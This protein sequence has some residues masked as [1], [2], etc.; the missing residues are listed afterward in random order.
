MKKVGIFICNY[1]GKQYV[2][3]CIRSLMSQT[4]Q[5][6]DIYVVDNASTDGSAEGIAENFGNTVHVLQNSDNLGGAGG[7]DR[8]LKYGLNSGYQYIALLDNDI[9]L[10]SEAIGKLYEYLEEHEDT[11]IVGAKI[12]VMDEPDLIQDF[13]NYIDFENYR[14]RLCYCNIK[15]SELIPEVHECDYVPSC[16]ILIRSEMLEIS[17]TM[18]A[19][20]FIYYDDIE[21][22]YKMRKNNFKVA[23]YGGAKVWHKGG[24]RK[25]AVNT[26]SKYYFLR[27]RL[28]FFAKYISDEKIE[29]FADAVM[30]DVFMQLYGFY[31]KGMKEL[32]D[33][34]MY[35]FDDFLHG[36]RGKAEEQK[37][38]NI[39]K[40][41]I[42]FFN[43]IKGKK[44]VFIRFIDNYSE[45]DELDI[46]HIFLFIL[47][48]IIQN[49]ENIETNVCLDCCGVNA[50]EFR[51]K[52]EKAM[53][54]NKDKFPEIL[55]V[56][57][58]EKEQS[59]IILQMCKHVNLVTEK[60]FPEIYV[61]QYCNCITDEKDY[62]YF[63]SHENTYG[64]FQAMYR[65]LLLEGIRKI[66]EGQ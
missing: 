29:I 35:A 41:D 34:T 15:D 56:N 64:L 59:D 17:G 9:T 65:P 14:E 20:N 60:I 57:E 24:F 54:V 36:V 39:I 4:M 6:F 58:R 1:N 53:G 21:L 38:F 44:R 66:R 55:V 40:R 30:K 50:D 2:I 46:Y 26:F 49:N 7:F 42:P 45:R 32:F 27:N 61:D 47:G 12:Y 13:G 63:T 48:G 52:L 5:D 18:P 19:D 25:A 16:A 23:A 43:I 31:N 51:T 37:I 62:R 10:D 3:D 33:T 11:G 28:N 8:G 22:S